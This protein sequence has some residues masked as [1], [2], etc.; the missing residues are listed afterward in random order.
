MIAFLYF[1]PP[2]PLDVDPSLLLL[3]RG[4]F[5]GIDF[6][7]KSDHLKYNINMA[8]IDSP[9]FDIP[10]PQSVKRL[11]KVPPVCL[12]KLED[13]HILDLIKDFGQEF[14]CS[15]GEIIHALNLA[16]GPSDV[17][18]GLA[19]PSTLH[20]YTVTA[21][22]F[23]R[24]CITLRAV[25]ELIKISTKGSRSIYSVSVVDAFMFKPKNRL[26]IPDQ[27]CHQLLAQIIRLKRPKVLLLCHTESYSDPWMHKFELPCKNGY[28]MSHEV[29]PIGETEIH[30]VQSFHPAVAVYHKRL[31]P[32][33]KALL[34]HHFVAAF[35][36]L[37]GPY[38]EPSVV[39]TIRSICAK[40][41]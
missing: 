37:H 7:E 32:E 19:R 26:L 9:F 13:L 39:E 29:I 33:Y 8:D 24:D 14:D 17:M 12:S 25:D 21:E 30:A 15:P 28:R 16:S 27:R 3:I 5:Y 34:L 10:V 11:L 23:I 6:S 22:K 31:N 41:R 1:Q 18:I 35:S 2:T 4:Y 36:L 40:N 38:N 20:D